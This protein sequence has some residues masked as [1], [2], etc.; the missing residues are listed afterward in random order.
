MN[1]K[2]KTMRLALMAM[3]ISIELL[4][5]FTPLGY[6]PLGFMNMTTLHIPVIIVGIVMGVKDG[7]ILGLVFG[8]TSV[9]RA[10]MMPIP[11]SFIFSPFITIGG[12]SG[13]FSSLLI[14]IVPRILIGVFAALIY[15]L[16]IKKHVKDVVAII[17]AAVAGTLTNTILV[18]SGIYFFFGEAYAAV[19]NIAYD[20]LIKSLMV[21][22]TTN[23]IVEAFLG[24]FIVLGVV[25]AITP[26]I[27]T[28]MR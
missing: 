21:V 18:M 9:F 20:L 16:L 13:N 5:T 26:F 2:K 8:L 17:L 7:A 6:I 10:T 23:G 28:N 19:T 24:A 11:T 27:K 3:F 14:A 1:R 15:Q 12:V 22:V 4:L 25:K